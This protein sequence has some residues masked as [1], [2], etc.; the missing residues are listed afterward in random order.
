MWLWVWIIHVAGAAVLAGIFASTWSDL[1]GNTLA[2]GRFGGPATA[3]ILV[4][5]FAH[6]SEALGGLFPGAAL[7]GNPLAFLVLAYAWLG[8]ILA[9]GILAGL[10]RSVPVALEPSADPGNGDQDDVSDGGRDLLAERGA[11]LG[12]P[13]L[14]KLLRDCGTWAGRFT[15]LMIAQIII[16]GGVLFLLGAIL[17]RISD[18]VL[19]PYPDPASGAWATFLY[20]ALLGLAYLVL[21]IIGDYAKVRMIREARRSAVL[22]W[23]AGLRW[24]LTR[25]PRALGLHL[26]FVLLAAGGS[27]LYWYVSSTGGLAETVIAIAL[28]QQAYLIFRAGLRVHWY[29][30]ELSLFDGSR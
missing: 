18:A 29:A 24:V 5:L 1:L 4:D 13:F 9:G 7:F 6:Q 16:L 11:D 23:W 27:V 21:G 10:G 22:A 26:V 14:G 19:G 28:V 3:N 12:L 25:L 2:A 8:V 15:R 17:G 30:A 20:L